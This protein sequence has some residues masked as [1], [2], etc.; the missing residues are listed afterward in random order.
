MHDPE[1]LYENAPCGYIS[2]RPSDDQVVKA[3]QTFLTWM[4]L[5]RDDVVDRRSF[6]DL[7]TAG[8]K[9]F[10]ET[11]LRP[12]LHLSGQANEVA[13]DLRRDDG[14][15]FSVLVNAV[16]DTD[17]LGAPLMTRIAVFDATERRRYEQQLLAAKERAEESEQ[18]YAELARTLQETLMPPRDPHI[19]GLEVATAY[20]PAGSGEEIGGDFYDVFAVSDSDWVV[21]IGDVAGKG[22]PAAVVATLA[23]HTIRSVAISE[24]SPAAVLA[25]LN[26]VLLGHP[27]ERHLTASVL[28]MRRT[29][30]RWDVAMALGGHPPAIVL[31]PGSEP[32]PLGGA[33]NL[34]GVFEHATYADMR[35][36]LRPGTTV[37]LHTDGVTEARGTGERDL[38]GEDRLM[39][40]VHS[41][42]GS[43]QELV[44]RVLRDVLEH[45]EN[46]ARDDI[47]LVALRVPLL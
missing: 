6:S 35:F 36:E 23:R 2:V 22:A 30:D 29:G 37:L 38:Y 24:E 15:R 42:L 47:A 21:T 40:L 19:D 10:H 5:E 44:D 7:L 3:N 33:G 1:A 13:L 31:A 12:L 32:Y 8:S 46:R 28:R 34:V 25:H 27:S 45:Q 14:S 17:G 4:G 11:H 16:M 9:V 26:Q 20:R 18:R 43:A 39:K 41:H